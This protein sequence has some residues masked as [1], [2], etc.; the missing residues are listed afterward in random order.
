MESQ[1]F[2]LRD[3]PTSVRKASSA[4]G[5]YRLRQSCRWLPNEQSQRSQG[6][7]IEEEAIANDPV[8]RGRSCVRSD[9]VGSADFC[10][11]QAPQKRPARQPSGNHRYLNDPNHILPPWEHQIN[12]M[13]SEFEFGTSVL[14]CDELSENLFQGGG[15]QDTQTPSGQGGGGSCEKAFFQ[16]GW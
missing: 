13:Y 3:T 2:R 7:V 4:E 10:L 5:G 12:K 6:C 8:Q 16:H 9:S 14:L 11:L 15:V 1:T